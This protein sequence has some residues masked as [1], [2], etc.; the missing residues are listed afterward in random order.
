MIGASGAELREGRI[1]LRDLTPPGHEDADG[2]AREELASSGVFRTYG[3]EFLRR[4]GRRVA[5]LLGGA[6]LPPP[7]EG[8][9]S[10]VLDI[11]ER[12]AVEEERA[13]LVRELREAVR[14]RD[15]FLAVAAHELRTPLTPLRLH[16]QSLQRA[17]D[18]SDPERT[19][20]ARLA[21]R[22][23]TVDASVRRLE[24][25]IDRLLD[26]SRLTVGRL[27]LELE[28]VDLA[29]VVREVVERARAEADP[30][31]SSIAL[32]AEQAV[33][34]RWDRLRLEQAATNL[35]SNAIKYGGGKPIEVEVGGDEERAW[36]VVR[37][38]GIGIPPDEQARIFERFERLAPVR[39][40]GGFGLG[41]WIVRQIIEAQG[42]VIEVDSRPGEGSCFTV[43]LPLRPATE[44]EAA[45]QT[46][47]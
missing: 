4:D 12:R 21:A 5:V 22:L 24:R 29:S 32:R 7:Q 43:R 41:L 16:V 45:E 15:D 40:F 3:K 42:G 13:R 20:P 28:D 25:L 37:D 18:R 17:L 47:H 10:F 6:R 14:A 44:A 33:V 2:R 8:D 36:L 1:N 23:S 39:N 9:V 26:V 46:M 34:G 35:L 30:A 19:N 27:R 11:T 31:G 38:H